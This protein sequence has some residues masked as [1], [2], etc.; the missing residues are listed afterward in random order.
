MNAKNQTK[1]FKKKTNK[2]KFRIQEN[3]YYDHNSNHDKKIKPFLDAIAS[4]NKEVN[5]ITYFI[6]HVVLTQYGMRKG[7]QV[8]CDQGLAAIKK[9]MKQFHDLDVITAINVKTMM[10]QQKSQALLYLMLAYS[11]FT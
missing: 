8:F 1:S 4:F 2:H 3:P 11:R 10:K 6:N 7:L 9:E 5:E